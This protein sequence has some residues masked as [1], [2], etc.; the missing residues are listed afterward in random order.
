MLAHYSPSSEWIP[1]GNT[2]EIKAARKGTGHPTSHADGSGCV[3]SLTGTPLR[4]EVYGTTFTLPPYLTNHVSVCLSTI[5]TQ[6]TAHF[7]I[8]K[9]PISSALKI[10]YIKKM[11]G[12]AIHIVFCLPST[13]SVKIRFVIL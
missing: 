12:L 13:L 5:Y 9:S 1:G 4:T 11:L 2:E 8:R 7:V 6:L 3:P 10:R